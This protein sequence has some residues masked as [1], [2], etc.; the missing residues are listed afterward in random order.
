MQ[1][2]A[3]FLDTLL[4]LR[5]DDEDESLGAG[6]VMSPK[7][8]DLVLPSDVLSL[9]G[10]VSYEAETAW[11]GG[12]DPD[13]ELDVLVRDGFDVEADCRYRRNGLI[14]LQFVQNRCTGSV[15]RSPRSLQRGTDSS[16][17]PR[18]ARA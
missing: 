18:R 12:A 15:S 9:R 10:F 11:E 14:Q 2:C 8:S 3:G 17:P 13:V 16:C 5:V 7:G 6:V 4:V 1:F